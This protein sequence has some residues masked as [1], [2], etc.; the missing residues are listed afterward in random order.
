MHNE[1]IIGGFGGQ[2]ILFLGKVLATAGMLEG[3]HV[4]WFPSYGPEMRG[5][6]ANCTVIISDQEIGATIS[7]HPHIVVAMNEP[8]LFRF[9][10][11]LKEGGLLLI[12]SSLVEKEYQKE[13][14]EIA[15]IPANQLAGKVVNNPKTLNMVVLG[16]LIGYR[17][18]LP[19]SQVHRALEECLAGKEGLIEKNNQALETGWQYACQGGV[20]HVS[21]R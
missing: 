1:I 2:G 18:I 15:K 6:T 20:T 4:S 5:G 9:A 14:I 7:D 17:P 11:S 8:S 3:Y 10:P 16:A 19:L 13:G 12:N 21:Q